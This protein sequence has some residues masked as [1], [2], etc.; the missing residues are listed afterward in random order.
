MSV[1]GTGI[2]AGVAQTGLT[3][4]QV[5]RQRDKRNADRTHDD[6]QQLLRFDAQLSSPGE[7]RDADQEL[8]DHQAPGYD[9]LYRG[10]KAP[11]APPDDTHDL[12]Q[13]P[14]PDQPYPPTSAA[15]GSTEAPLYQHLDIQA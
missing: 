8:P 1:L 15:P 14:V 4:Q 7:T 5:G 9:M 11:E 13:P 3:A 12:I 2:A 6:A 10:Q